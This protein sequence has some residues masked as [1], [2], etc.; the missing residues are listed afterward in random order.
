MIQQTFPEKP[1]IPEAGADHHQV[2]H[3]LQLLHRAPARAH[4]RRRHRAVRV[5]GERQR[6]VEEQE[7]EPLRWPRQASQAEQTPGDLHRRTIWESL[8]QL[9]QGRARYSYRDWYRNHALCLH[10]A[11]IMHR[12]WQV[13]KK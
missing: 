12:Y 13:K 2:R 11:S 3:G 6:G 1:A 10:S 9:L 7:S 5:D 4:L 8:E